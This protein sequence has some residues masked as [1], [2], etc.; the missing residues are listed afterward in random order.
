MG[1]R[2]V[3][4]LFGSFGCLVRLVRLVVPFR[5]CL[6]SHLGVGPERGLCVV[7]LRLIR[8]R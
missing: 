3:V 2:R 1:D 7:G 6:G 5:I 8:A 4:W